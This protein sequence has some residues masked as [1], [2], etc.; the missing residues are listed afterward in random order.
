ME[1]QFQFPVHG[2]SVGKMESAVLIPQ[3]QKGDTI[4]S[5]PYIRLNGK[6]RCKALR[7]TE[8]I[9][10]SGG[11]LYD[12]MFAEEEILSSGYQKVLPYKAE[13]PFA[14]WM[15]DARLV[16]REEIYGCAGAKKYNLLH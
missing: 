8:A 5:L 10:G 12:Q 9:Q 1:I 4:L 14:P 3:L 13:V 16:V 11:Q 6:S 15:A 7:R 2:K